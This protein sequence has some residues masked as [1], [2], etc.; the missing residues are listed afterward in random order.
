[1]HAATGFL[2]VVSGVCMMLAL[3]LYVAHAIVHTAH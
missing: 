2:A 3:V 1:M